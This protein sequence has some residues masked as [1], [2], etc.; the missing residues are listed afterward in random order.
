[1]PLNG[2][3]LEINSKKYLIQLIDG[4]LFYLGKL[5]ERKRKLSLI[6]QN[7]DIQNYIFVFQHNPPINKS[8]YMTLW[9][10][11]RIFIEADALDDKDEFF[12]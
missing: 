6:M 11:Y 1:M 7:D 3:E 2:N 10:H 9:H 12:V 4:N 5:L 8:F